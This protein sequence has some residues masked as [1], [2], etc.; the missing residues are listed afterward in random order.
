MIR[1]EF[2]KVIQTT[3]MLTLKE[4]RKLTLNKDLDQVT[5]FELLDYRHFDDKKFAETISDKT[6]IPFLDISQATISPETIGMLKKGNIR[7]FRSC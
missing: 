4:L 6:S 7:K 3:G 1:E 2:I 5:E